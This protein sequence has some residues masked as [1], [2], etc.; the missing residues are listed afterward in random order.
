MLCF[1][2][3]AKIEIGL[4]YFLFLYSVCLYIKIMSVFQRVA[5]KS[6]RI[7]LGLMQKSA[8]TEGPA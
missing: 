1:F 2:C 5:E 4:F 7:A 3:N 8:W 6:L